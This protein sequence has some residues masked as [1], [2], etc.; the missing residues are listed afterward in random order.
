MNRV[1]KEDVAYDRSKANPRRP[2]PIPLTRGTASDGHSL[3]HA[4][5]PTSQPAR[6]AGVVK[7]VDNAHSLSLQLSPPGDKPTTCKDGGQKVNKEPHS[8]TTDGYDW[9]QT[10]EFKKIACF[11]YRR[12]L[13]DRQKKHDPTASE[14][15]TIFIVIGLL[16]LFIG[17]DRGSIGAGLWVAF[18]G[19]IVFGSYFG[20][21]LPGIIHD[22]DLPSEKCKSAFTGGIFASFF[23]YILVLM[24]SQINSPHKCHPTCQWCEEAIEEHEYQQGFEDT[25]PR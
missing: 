5:Q 7:L 20:Q 16:S 12:I 21:I 23:F 6:S 1:V 3:T 8:S 17:R 9:Y 19:F 22:N 10:D 24:V 15:R 13:E 14:T 2:H 4:S 18:S 25:D 11:E